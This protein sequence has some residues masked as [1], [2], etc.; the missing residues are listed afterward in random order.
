MFGCIK[1]ANPLIT[2]CTLILSL[3]K[4]EIISCVFFSASNVSSSDVIHEYMNSCARLR[5]KPIDKL[6]KQL[7]VIITKCQVQP[8][9]L[10]DNMIASIVTRLTS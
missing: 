8:I 9:H 7:K 10:E 3:H 1:I 2:Y 6:V 4:M 5:V